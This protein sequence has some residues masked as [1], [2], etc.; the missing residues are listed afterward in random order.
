MSQRSRE[1]RSGQREVPVTFDVECDDFSVPEW[2]G[3]RC[4]ATYEVFGYVT[5]DRS[6][7]RTTPNGPPTVN[8]SLLDSKTYGISMTFDEDDGV[9]LPNW[10]QERLATADSNLFDAAF[11][12]A[13]GG[14]EKL[15]QLAIEKASE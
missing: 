11:L 3:L 5:F 8:V 6:G 1:L 7:D 15:D 12:T 14:Q 4:S 9:D 10:L 2:P 13:I